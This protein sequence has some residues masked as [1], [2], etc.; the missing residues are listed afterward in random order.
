MFLNI[1]DKNFQFPLLKG[2]PPVDML[3][4]SPQIP[5]NDPK[6]RFLKENEG[7]TVKIGGETLENRSRTL[8]R[9]AWNILRT[10][11]GPQ[12][13]LGHFPYK[14]PHI[15]SLGAKT[16]WGPYNVRKTFQAIPASVL[17]RFLRIFPRFL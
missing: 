6:S 13:V 8:V 9:I 11:Y 16:I 17:E 4:E 7:K 14:I 5:Q 3:W 10:L 15:C 2:G 12:M 1:F